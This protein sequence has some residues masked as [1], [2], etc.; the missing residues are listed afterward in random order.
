M[1]QQYN[2][3]GGFY[4]GTG[5]K[6]LHCTKEPYVLLDEYFERVFNNC[7]VIIEPFSK[8]GI[9]GVILVVTFREEYLAG[10]TF[11]DF[12][13]R[14]YSFAPC[15][16]LLFKLCYIDPGLGGKTETAF[17]GKMMASKSKFKHEVNIQQDVFRRTNTHYQPITPLIYLH[18]IYDA[19]KS[20][21]FLN[22]IYKC[23]SAAAK[24]RLNPIFN[25]VQNYGINLGVILMEMRD[26]FVPMDSIS[27]ALNKL[28]AAMVGEV[29]NR[30]HKTCGITH[31]DL[32]QRNILIEIQK[33][34]YYAPYAGGILLIDWGEA[35]SYS[36]V[37]DGNI[38]PQK[39]ANIELE[40]TLIR[41]P[42]G[43]REIYWSYKWLQGPWD[44]SIQ[45]ISNELRVVRQ[46]NYN[47]LPQLP[48]YF[49]QPEITKN[50]G[51]VRGGK[52]K[53]INTNSKKINYKKKYLKYKKKYLQQKNLH[54]GGSNETKKTMDTFVRSTPEDLLCPEEQSEISITF[55]EGE[56]ELFEIEL[57]D[58]IINSLLVS[59]TRKLEMPQE[60]KNIIFENKKSF[61][62]ELE[63]LLGDLEIDS[64][65]TFNEQGVEPDAR[66][67]TNLT[68][69]EFNEKIFIE[70]TKI[71]FLSKNTLFTGLLENFPNEFIP[72]IPSNTLIPLAL[73]SIIGLGP[74]NNNAWIAPHSSVI[75]SREEW[76]Q[77]HQIHTEIKAGS[78]HQYEKFFK[79]GEDNKTYLEEYET[80]KEIITKTQIF[81]EE[82]KINNEFIKIPTFNEY[83]INIILSKDEKSFID[84]FGAR[85]GFINEL[86]LRQWYA[87]EYGPPTF[88]HNWSNYLENDEDLQDNPDFQLLN[89]Q[90]EEGKHREVLRILGV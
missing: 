67:S 30:L 16:R 70:L 45:D 54:F 85:P 65:L 87:R 52:S 17:E 88:P 1:V 39:E 40:A 78:K 34:D 15:K 79:P 55:S 76:E 56:P 36:Y 72:Y 81:L 14:D 23:C 9:R 44:P 38:I 32:H 84:L 12:V 53:K 63:I 60:F 66:L 62:I 31:G 86:L 37:D 25:Y 51:E 41:N 58:I 29:L 5:T 35:Q 73:Y 47:E 68:F 83:L 59:F 24:E 90:W 27:G 33:K 20:I 89:D 18:K 49:Y 61:N 13:I 28:H 74:V 7:N 64:S 43:S 3:K 75:F 46:T 6:T 48:T 10:L 42:P 2:L 77:I 8:E 69:E 26:G 80:V 22:V 11:E 50:W 57:D 71:V 82:N 21:H 19:E 4:F